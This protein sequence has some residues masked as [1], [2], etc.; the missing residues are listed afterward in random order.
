MTK[1]NGV[2]T[3]KCRS[4]IGLFVRLTAM[5]ATAAMLI[6]GCEKGFD[7]ASQIQTLR[8]VGVRADKP[9]PKPG[10]T[11]EFEMLWHDGS[12]PPDSPRPVQIV[13]IGGCFNPAGDLYYQCFE[14][15]GQKLSALEEDPSRINEVLGFGETY[16]LEIPSD[17]ISNRNVA[18]G[19]DPY[20]LTVVF[21]AACAG[22]L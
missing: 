3:A 8:I 16:S 17:I 20:G 5:V 19:V 10:E 7:P 14:Q 13:W 12:S 4:S 15:L 21:F 1:S 9:Y 11:V 6:T 18:E 22:T 2:S